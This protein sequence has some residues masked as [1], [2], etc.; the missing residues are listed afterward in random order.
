M[1]DPLDDM[2]LTENR[3]L[4]GRVLLRQPAEGYRVAIDPVLL[5]ASVPAESGELVLDL[6]CG[7]GAAA[8]CLLTRVQGVGVTGLELQR[9]LVRLAGQNAALNGLQGR[10]TVM[11]G[12]LLQPP[13]RLSPGMFHHVMANPPHLPA[14]A[15]R[16]P[17][18]A[19]EAV[20]A[21]ESDA[22]LADWVRVAATMV[23]AKGTVTFVHR[24]DRL[25]ALLAAMREH[26][27]GIVVFPL[28]PGVGKP[29]VRVLVRA[30][31]N[32]A[33]PMVLAPGL[34]LH[35][36]DGA[37]TPEAEAVLREAAPLLF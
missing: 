26:L 6:G 23:R 35:G 28:W 7:V 11:E 14:A 18:D 9:P 13:P 19:M 37:F 17:T 4:G 25:D 32:I 10:C 22:R 5:A 1:A 27:G 30:R 2:A 21:V 12:S 20:A 15:G 8:L 33:A 36:H 34:L 29:A 3:L 24:A 31:R 16:P